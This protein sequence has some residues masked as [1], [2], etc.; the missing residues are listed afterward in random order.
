MKVTLEI[1]YRDVERK[2]QFNILISRFVGFR[3][4]F[5]KNKNYVRILKGDLISTTEDINIYKKRLV[6]IDTFKSI[7]WNLKNINK[8]TKKYLLPEDI[9]NQIN[10][11]ISLD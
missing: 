1:A 10:K 3:S 11:I 8:I 4:L 7:N 5:I 9:K 6:L 2:D